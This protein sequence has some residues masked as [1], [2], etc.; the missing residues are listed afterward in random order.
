[1][2]KIA[3]RANQNCGESWLT[4]EPQKKEIFEFIILF[5]LSAILKRVSDYFVNEITRKVLSKKHASE[6]YSYNL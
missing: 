1:M 4:V 6:R 3:P 5:F 2:K